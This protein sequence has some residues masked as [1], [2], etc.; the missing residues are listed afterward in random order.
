MDGIECGHAELKEA[1][2][3]NAR[4][5]SERPVAD[6]IRY[7]GATRC[8]SFGSDRWDGGMAHTLRPLRQ[9]VTVVTK[10]AA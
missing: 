2:L 6:T 10:W 5:N 3:E 1:G 4:A 9:K 7:I 8:C